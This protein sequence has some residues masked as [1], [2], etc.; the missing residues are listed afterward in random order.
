MQSVQGTKNCIEILVG[1]PVLQLSIKTV[2]ILFLSIAQEPL[3]YLNL[4]LFLSS[5]DNLL[6]VVY[7]F[8]FFF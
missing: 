5:L 3:G 7:V 6:Q 8:F 1:K 4:V 2:K